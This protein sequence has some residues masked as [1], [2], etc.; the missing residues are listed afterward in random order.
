MLDF[1]CIPLLGR[2][3]WLQYVLSLRTSGQALKVSSFE[4]ASVDSLCEVVDPLFA[5]SQLQAGASRWG[6]MTG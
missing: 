5:F 2:P 1:G 3:Q 6:K 4:S